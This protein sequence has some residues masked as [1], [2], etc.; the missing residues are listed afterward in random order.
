MHRKSESE[1]ESAPFL[2]RF[3][4]SSTYIQHA[5]LVTAKE[6]FTVYTQFPDMLHDI[7]LEISN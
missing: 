2:R 5:C 1:I 4:H 3:I 7:K 6:R